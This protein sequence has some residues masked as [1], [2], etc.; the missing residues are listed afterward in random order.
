MKVKRKPKGYWTQTNV[1]AELVRLQNNG[2][3]MQARRIQEVASGLYQKVYYF[4]NS[5][6]DALQDAGIDPNDYKPKRRGKYLE[7]ADIITE[8]KRRKEAGSSL[9]KK[10]VRGDEERLHT[11]AQRYFGTWENAL[12]EAGEN[13]RDH[14]GTRGMYTYW[15]EDTVLDELLQRERDGKSMTAT[16]IHAD[17]MSLYRNAL[18]YYG[19]WETVFKVLQREKEIRVDVQ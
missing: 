14:K 8:I 1:R 13:P 6:D 19:N 12:L 7:K 4:Y 15:G 2:Q 5:W 9:V 18:K 3:D 17:D 11:H 10:D 16:G